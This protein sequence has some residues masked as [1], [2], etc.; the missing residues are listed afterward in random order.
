MSSL[1]DR[2]DFKPLTR[3]DLPLLLTWFQRP[4]MREWWG[5][6]DEEI[7]LVRDMLEG[8][9]TTRPFLFQLDGR[10]IGYIQYWFIGHHQNAE[11]LEDHPWLGEFPPDALGIDLSIGEPQLVGRGLGSTVLRAFAERLVASGYPTLV[12]D[13]DPDNLRAIRAYEKAG[14]GPV[15]HL[16]GMTG[17]ALI[18]QFYPESD[19]T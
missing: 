18:M 7:A 9:D 5:E 17:D 1:R 16:E 10:P 4:H 6:P 14:F 12:I 19:G 8:R 2:I 13:P 11:W 3:G 15:T